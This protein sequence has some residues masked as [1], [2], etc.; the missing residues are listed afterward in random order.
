MTGAEEATAGDN[1]CDD[2]IPALPGLVVA[3]NL[4]SALKGYVPASPLPKMRLPWL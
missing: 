4:V 1:S 2:V 3:G